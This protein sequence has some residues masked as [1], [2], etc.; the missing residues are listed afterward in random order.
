MD[1][2]MSDEMKVPELPLHE[3]IKRWLWAKDFTCSRRLDVADVAEWIEQ[4]TAERIAQQDAVIERLQAELH[5]RDLQADLSV[6]YWEKEAALERA[7][8]A[9]K[10][11]TDR[12]SKLEDANLEI[13]N[14]KATVET[15]KGLLREC[16]RALTSGAGQGMTTKLRAEIIARAQ[17]QLQPTQGEQR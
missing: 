13:E 7:E 14:L 5:G 9:G 12:D 1:T 11:F 15:L 10:L 4:Y 2:K 8:N 16:V 17:Q 3:Q 6:P